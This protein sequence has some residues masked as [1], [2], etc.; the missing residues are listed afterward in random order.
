MT[1]KLDFW[2]T[3]TPNDWIREGC[4]IADQVRPT[5]DQNPTSRDHC[6][7]P[8]RALIALVDRLRQA[9][10][11][12]AARNGL[13]SEWGFECDSCGSRPRQWELLSPDA[14][15]GDQCPCCYLDD[16]DCDGRLV[17][18][19]LERMKPLPSDIVAAVSE[20][21]WNLLSKEEQ[22]TERDE[23]RASLK[24]CANGCNR[25]PKR[26][27]KVIC[28]ECQDRITAKLEAIVSSLKTRAAAMRDEKL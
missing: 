14:K 7:L 9:T 11:E 10:E 21:F 1:G 3:W 8:I 12:D 18:V 23:Q 27:S 15:V 19:E 22:A 28:G 20:E 24:R 17:A 2:K 26:P 4:R 5:L 25:P 6:H 13:R 16:Y